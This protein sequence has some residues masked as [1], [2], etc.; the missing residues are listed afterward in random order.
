MSEFISFGSVTNLANYFKNSENSELN[1][2]IQSM[3]SFT[4][5]IILG[6]T[7]KL[8]EILRT[9]KNNIEEF[10]QSKQTTSTEQILL[11]MTDTIQSKFFSGKE[12]DYLSIITWCLDNNLIQQAL[13]L[14]TEKIPDYLFNKNILSVTDERKKDLAKTKLDGYGLAYY[15]FYSD[16]MEP[17]AEDNQ[18][19]DMYK[20]ICEY[21]DRKNLDK[22]HK[23]VQKYKKKNI[24][25]IKGIENFELLYKSMENKTIRYFLS[26]A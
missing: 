1:A 7:T 12:I 2:L 26:A 3:Q 9:F 20:F 5:A 6:K 4:N 13:T 21:S 23:I 8:E 22:G 24:N 10:K 15:I 11:Y 18:Y 25:I 19:N 16:F 14:Y 17:I